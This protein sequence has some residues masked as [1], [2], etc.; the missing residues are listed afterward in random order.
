MKS[1]SLLYFILT[2]A[3]LYAGVDSGKDLQAPKVSNPQCNAKLSGDW[4]FTADV[5][6]WYIAQQTG[7]D[8][9]ISKFNTSTPTI[10]V[11][12]LTFPW[13]WGFRAGIG[14]D[15]KYDNWTTQLLYTWFHTSGHDSSHAGNVGSA[16]DGPILADPGIIFQ[17]GSIKFNF[18]FNMFDW[19][20]GR[21]FCASRTVSFRPF[22][23]IKGGWIFQHLN[24]KWKNADLTATEK[25][26][27]DFFGIGPKGGVEGKWNLGRPAHF[28]LFAVA[29][30]AFLWGHWSFKDVYQNSTPT[31]FV[32]ELPTN[33]FGGVMLRG[34]MGFGWDV[35]FNNNKSNFSARLS[36]EGQ[37]WFDQMQYVTFL[38]GV[39]HQ[40]LTMQGATL[41]L[42]VDF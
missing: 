33:R 3:G 42:R 35:P 15:T 32:I 14:Y 18:L 27:N 6:Y 24:T 16:F 12:E 9:A 10:K 26:K 37:L 4:S 23:G 21:R 22:L 41:D 25:I 39:L 13:S 40:N 17:S 36:Y 7:T 19:D 1:F 8:W 20:L 31:R 38:I 28:N 30:G 5:L 29:E 2:A 34:Q 11:N